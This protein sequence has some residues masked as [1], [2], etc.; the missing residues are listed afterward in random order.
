MKCGMLLLALTSWVAASCSKEDA[1]TPKPEADGPTTEQ[2]V[3]TRESRNYSG[4]VIPYRKAVIAAG[5]ERGKTA[6]VLYLHG[7]TS[8]GADNERP[9]QEPGVRAISSYLAAQRIAAVVIV[10]QCPKE[11]S[12]GGAMNDVLKALIDGHIL[13][14]EAEAERIYIL[15]G[16][17]G[18]T[19]TWSMLSA[20][21][22]LF[23]AAMPVAG[24]PSGCRIE[25]V[26]GTPVL[27][28]MGS[29]DRIMDI[30]LV[31]QFV[32]K[33][34]ESGGEAVLETQEGWTHEQTCTQSYTDARLNWVFGH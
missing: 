30:G 26:S 32:E 22:G 14:G 20:Y 29:S 1:A 25:N 6:L 13:Q 19:G 24:N 8:K 33:L 21:P 16:S 12:W 28:V 5:N 15:G 11:R 7:G 18:G 17:M 23:A 9:V 27:T 34:V 31:S 2:I 3:F 4:L 10:P